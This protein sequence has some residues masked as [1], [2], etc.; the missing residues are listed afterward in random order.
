MFYKDSRKLYS[1]KKLEVYKTRAMGDIHKIY[2]TR[3]YNPCNQN[4][5]RDDHS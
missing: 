5:I 1:L 2:Y 3:L 4:S